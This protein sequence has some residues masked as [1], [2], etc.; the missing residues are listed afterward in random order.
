MQPQK[1]RINDRRER[2][3]FHLYDSSSLQ[4]LSQHDQVASSDA[5]DGI[6]TITIQNVL[7]LTFTSFFFLCSNNRKRYGTRQYEHIDIHRKED[8]EIYI[9]NLFNNFLLIDRFSFFFK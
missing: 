7:Y 9:D 5:V 3:K 6:F 1:N 8:N 4:S 2:E